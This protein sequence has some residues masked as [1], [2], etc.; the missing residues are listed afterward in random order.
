M[1]TSPMHLDGY[2]IAQSIDGATAAARTVVRADTDSRYAPARAGAAAIGD[3]ITAWGSAGPTQHGHVWW[4]ILGV[5]TSQRIRFEAFFATAG[6]TLEQIETTHL[7]SVL[8]MSPLPGA[9]FVYGGTNNL[10]A[11][12]SITSLAA[13]M[14]RI[15]T[16]LEAKGILPVLFLLQ[17]RNGSASGTQQ[18]SQWNT[19]L[20]KFA[21]DHGYPIVDMQGPLVDPTT[22][23]YLN[24]MLSTTDGT[25]V[26]PSNLGHLTAMNVAATNTLLT[27][28]FSDSGI[29]LTQGVSDIANLVGN[30]SLFLT[31]TNSDGIPDGWQQSGI[32]ASATAALV[33]SSNGDAKG[34]WLRLSKTNGQTG[35]AYVFLDITTGYTIGHSFELSCRIRSSAGADSSNWVLAAIM[36]GVNTTFD[37]RTGGTVDGVAYIRGVIPAGTTS[38]RVRCMLVGTSTEACHADFA[39]ITLHD[40]TS[41]SLK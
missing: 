1:S 13:T 16:A 36:Q 4:N 20:R 26:H 33:A 15:T 10:G 9:C 24:G 41:L 25:G 40:L 22:G 19:H 29:Y 12:F 28:R 3:S 18:T 8:T 30:S 21:A 7:P 2:S 6:F 38:I 23:G 34:Q 14:K 17:P 35:T 5:Q 39:Q 27:S 32:T 37:T 11:G 31:D